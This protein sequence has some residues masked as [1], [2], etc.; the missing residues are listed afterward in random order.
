MGLIGHTGSIGF[1]NL[2][3]HNNLVNYIGR[4]S[5]TISLGDIISIVN[6][7]GLVGHIGLLSLNGLL[8]LSL[9][10][11]SLA[12]LIGHISFAV[13]IGNISLNGLGFIG[14][15]SLGLVGIISL[16][17]LLASSALWLICLVSRAVLLAHCWPH[18]LVAAMLAVACKQA[19]HGVATMLTSANKI[20]SMAT[21]YFCATSSLHVS[22]NVRETMWWWLAVARKR[23]GGGLPC[24]AIPTTMTRSKI[25]LPQLAA[26]TR[27]EFQQLMQA[28][29]GVIMASSTTKITNAAI[30]CHCAA[31]HWFM[32]E[33]LL[34][35]VLLLLV[36]LTH[37]SSEI[38][39]KMQINYF[40]SGFH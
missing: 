36:D 37:S 26:A 16:I 3:S 32:R 2:I 20:A 11:L 17:G 18:I 34:W 7:T 1:N 15:I 14:L 38:H 22:I 39:Y 35:H 21:L 33:S 8:D 25:V 40:L 30:W 12:R 4:V 29:H 28:A 10:S 27:T 5:H 23:Y 24:L 19:E 9:I 13:L 31:S 6:H